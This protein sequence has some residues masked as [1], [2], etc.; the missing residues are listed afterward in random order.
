MVQQGKQCVHSFLTSLNS[1][2]DVKSLWIEAVVIEG[3][4]GK[5]CTYMIEVNNGGIMEC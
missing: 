4:V 1:S 2:M 5:E 3:M